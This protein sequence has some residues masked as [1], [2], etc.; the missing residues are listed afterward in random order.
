MEVEFLY[1]PTLETLVDR[2]RDRDALLVHIVHF[3]G[4]G[5]YD[6]ALGLGY[7]LFE[8]DEH[9]SDRVD[10][11]RLGMLLNR[12]GVPLMVLNATQGAKLGEATAELTEEIRRSLHY[13]QGQDQAVPLTQLILSGR[14]A[15]VKNLDSQLS[16]ALSMPVAIGNPLLLLAENASNMADADLAFM[17]P[18]LSI[19]V[20]LALPEED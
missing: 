7:L 3:D 10:A 8:N 14:G 18:Y 12:C 13:Y 16:E 11:N 5:V 20:G 1:P 4:Y 6:T 15:L 17:A 2:L 19:A 9:N